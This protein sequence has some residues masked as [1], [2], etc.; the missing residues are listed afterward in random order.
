MM[1]KKKRRRDNE[2]IE[3]VFHDLELLRN[4]SN[5]DDSDESICRV[6]VYGRCQEPKTQ[7]YVCH[8]FHCNVSLCFYAKRLTY[9]K[10]ANHTEKSRSFGPLLRSN[11]HQHR[12]KKT[13]TREDS[14]QI[15]VPETISVSLSHVQT[16]H[17]KYRFFLQTPHELD[18]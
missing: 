12:H 6:Q 8:L 17:E 3:K 11:W 9:E 1:F 18:R 13:W 7:N 15:V 5:P 14:A 4:S 2:L 16:G 10:L